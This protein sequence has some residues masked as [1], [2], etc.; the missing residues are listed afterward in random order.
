MPRPN[1][2][3]WLGTCLRARRPQCG[4]RQQSLLHHGNVLLAFIFGNVVTPRVSNHGAFCLPD[5]VELTIRFHLANK[6]RFV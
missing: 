3:A 1:Q 5:H 2:N 6:D 4:G